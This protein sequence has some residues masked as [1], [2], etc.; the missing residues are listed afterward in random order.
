MRQKG[1]SQS[2][3]YNVYSGDDVQSLQIWRPDNHSKRSWNFW[4]K[5]YFHR[6]K[7]LLKYA[8]YQSKK[9]CEHHKNNS[10]H[11]QRSAFARSTISHLSRFPRYS[12]LIFYFSSLLSFL[13]AGMG[14]RRKKE[15]YFQATK[16]KLALICWKSSHE[17][18][19]LLE[20]IWY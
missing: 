12:R 5:I 8:Q 2:L 18:R 7:F 10:L 9:R 15:C 6:R 14:W 13:I 16:N 3:L 17:L 20:Q 1:Q 19:C 11:L 4:W